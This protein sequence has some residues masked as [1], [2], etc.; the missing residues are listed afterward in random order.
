MG[1]RSKRADG[2]AGFNDVGRRR[3]LATAATRADTAV[4]GQP[5]GIC[6]RNSLSRTPQLQETCLLILR[7][8]ARAAASAGAS[9]YDVH[10]IIG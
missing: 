7:W 9:R 5:G 2:V 4:G 3:P 8:A 6:L 1:S 10:V